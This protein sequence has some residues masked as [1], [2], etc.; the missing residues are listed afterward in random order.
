MLSKKLS[1]DISLQ[2]SEK[3][4]KTK[5]KTEVHKQSKIQSDFD[6]QNS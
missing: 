1:L 4:E 6:Y 2:Q 3:K 5:N